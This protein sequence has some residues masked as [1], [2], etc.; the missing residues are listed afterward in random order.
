VRAER[1]GDLDGERAH[2]ATRAVDQD[3]LPGLHSASIAQT[4]QC[5]D[6]RDAHR[7]R[8]RE[9]KLR[10]LRDEAVLSRVCELREGASGCAEHLSARPQARHV[11]ADGLHL[12]GHIRTPNGGRGLPQ[13]EAD[14]ADQSPPDGEAAGGAGSNDDVPATADEGQTAAKAPAAKTD[15]PAKTAPKRKAKT[16]AKRKRS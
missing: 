4:L 3:S 13:Q 10:R 5:G 14:R 1:L 15:P 8:L 12:A 11:P 2:A 9:R 16:A 6:A 7:A